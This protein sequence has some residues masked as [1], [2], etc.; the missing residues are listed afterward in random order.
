MIS[1]DKGVK[2]PRWFERNEVAMMN[3][4]FK[5]RVLHER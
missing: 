5:E 2:G 4:L 1:W 3:Q